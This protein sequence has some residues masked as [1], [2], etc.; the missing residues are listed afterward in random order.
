MTVSSIQWWE[1]FRAYP[2][3]RDEVACRN[4]PVRATR[5]RACWVTEDTELRAR[6]Q[7]RV[8]DTATDPV[9]SDGVLRVAP[10]DCALGVGRSLENRDVC[11]CVCE[12][13]L[14]HVSHTLPKYCGHVVAMILQVLY[15]VHALTHNVISIH[16]YY[17]STFVPSKVRKYLLGVLFYLRRYS[18]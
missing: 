14:E 2:K 12:N 3:T 4:R 13:C 1:W 6:V 8:G 17:E 7:T 15:S 5:V 10:P 9:R 16:C 11:V 18:I